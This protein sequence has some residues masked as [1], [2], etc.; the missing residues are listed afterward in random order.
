MV[1][2]NYFLEELRTPFSSRAVWATSP[3]SLAGT[4]TWW[5]NRMP[6]E[7]GD[8][9]RNPSQNPEMM[10]EESL[11][12]GRIENPIQLQNCLGKI[13]SC[14]IPNSL[15]NLGR[16]LYR[17]PSELCLLCATDTSATLSAICTK[18]V[19]KL[20][21]FLPLCHRTLHKPCLLSAPEPSKPHQPSRTLQNLVCTTPFETSSA[22]CT[23]TL[24]NFISHLHWN[25]PE[26]HQ[27]SA[28]EPSGISSAICIRTLRNF[29]SFLRHNPP[30]L[31]QPSAPEPSGISS[32]ICTRTLRN[33]ISFLRHNP[34]ELHQPSAPEPSG[35]LSAICTGTHRNLI[36]PGT[37]WNLISF[38]H[39]NP[40]EPHHL[41]RNPPEP[42]Q[43]SA[44]EPSGTLRNLLRNL[45]LQLHR[46]AP[47]LFWAKD[48]IASFAV[49]EKTHLNEIMMNM[50]KNHPEDCKLWLCD[51]RGLDSVAPNLGTGQHSTVQNMTKSQNDDKLKNS[52][53]PSH[54]T[55]KIGIRSLK[56]IFTRK[57]ELISPKS[58]H[59]IGHSPNGCGFDVL[60]LPKF[61]CL[62]VVFPHNSLGLSSATPKF[63]IP[64]FPRLGFY[65]AQVRWVATTMSSTGLGSCALFHR[66]DLLR[67]GRGLQAVSKTFFSLASTTLRI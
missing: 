66:L 21:C 13:N 38:L 61:L 15:E 43:P 35:T 54:Q 12:L 31:H 8:K 51:I 1:E 62:Q 49:G 2:Q 18:T 34:P 47:E 30:E 52:N 10:M 63:W 60:L 59:Q 24:W 20:V 50:M 65:S 3:G 40:P 27:P 44:P 41:H 28:P 5:W 11:F 16:T 67:L 39:R 53:T 22:I 17:N 19:R 32:A 36:C 56:A 55:K 46:I 29:I 23:G 6:K 7:W 45:L 4:R 42:H 25:P 26:L 48:P 64:L 58:Q 9:P 57:V 14:V 33:F 37:L